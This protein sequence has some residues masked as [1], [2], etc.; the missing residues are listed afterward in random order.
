MNLLKR[1]IKY[2]YMRICYYLRNSKVKSIYFDSFRGQ[3]SDSPRAISEAIHTLNPLITLYWSADKGEI[4]PNYIKKVPA[5][6]L[7][8]AKV[9]AQANAW[10]MHGPGN[11]I[12]GIYKGSS[13]YS[14][15]T[16]HGDRGFKK[17]GWA[18]FEEMGDS[19]HLSNKIPSF[20]NVDLYTVASR[21]G[22]EEYAYRGHHYFGEFIK[23]GLP[24]NDKLVN[25]QKYAGEISE[26]KR[27]LNIPA[28][29][30][31]LLY[32]PTFRDGKGLQDLSVDLDKILDILS[33]RDKWICLVRAHSSSA[34][35][36][37][38]GTNRFIDVSH[39]G[40]MADY[41]LIADV[42]ISDYSSC[43]TDFI[44]TE[45]PCVLAHYDRKEYEDKSRSL[46]MDP[47]KIGF[48]IAHNPFEMEN[49][50]KNLFS[51]DHKQIS[52]KVNDFYGTC[53]SGNAAMAIAK[54]ILKE[55]DKQ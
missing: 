9:M 7:L 18:A 39:H 41:L 10:V 31:V 6:S 55:I 11:K 2:N 3:Y 21:F 49:I 24:R 45:R 27:R 16:W 43:A 40:D 4:F 20:D 30:K 29:V 23:Q 22:M 25:S 19:Y 35:F 13:V 1:I 14:V 47:D 51:Y 34:G 42:L 5:K 28:D 15:A 38:E 52:K 33:Q 53:E 32:A 26:I 37:N 44:L 36:K 54:R 12:H 17:I 8:E 46:V 50:I 48:L